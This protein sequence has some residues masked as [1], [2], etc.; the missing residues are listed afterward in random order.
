MSAVKLPRYPAS[1]F[2]SRRAQLPSDAVRSGA[3]RI[4]ED[5]RAHGLKAALEHARRLGDLEEGAPALLERPALEATL[6]ALPRERRQVLERTA[7]RVRA[8]AE[9]H[10]RALTDVR[11]RVPGGEAGVLHAPVGAAG[12]YAPGGRFPLPSSVLMTA[13]TA[14]A[15]GVPSVIVASPRPGPETQAAAA[16]AGADRLLAIGGAQAIAALAFGVGDLV[17][18][19][20]IVGPGNAWVTAAK[21]LLSGEV[22]IDMLAGPSE[23]LALV[24]DR[25]DP[26]TVAA[27]LLAQAEHDPE[28]F[29]M[30]V[31]MSE[32]FVERVDQELCRQLEELPTR[33]IARESLARGAAVIAG[34]LEEASRV[35]NALAPEHLALHVE[36]ARALAPKLTSYGALFLGEGSAEVFGDYG[37]GP[38]HVLPTGGTARSQGALSVLDF[39]RPQMWLEL[40]PEGSA[41]LVD[42]VAALARMEG[43]EGH[44]RAAL[45]RPRSRAAAA[46]GLD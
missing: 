37:A 21:Q 13:I 31:A 12:C 33:D 11:V 28:A 8:F 42:D 43:L 19:D 14:K 38:N 44:A 27:D 16:L 3:R 17:A 35:A 15:A 18:C 41:D 2:P 39:L 25:A 32:A 29:P 26:A 23:L 9:A 4:I 6:A 45:R 1:A 5:V 30:L 46:R 34:D 20:V 36:D 10:R 24:D 40:A 22:R 7:D